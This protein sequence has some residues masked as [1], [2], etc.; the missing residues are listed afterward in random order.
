VSAATP[1]RALLACALAGGLLALA[2]AQQPAAKPAATKPAPAAAKPAPKPAAMPAKQPPA[3]PGPPPAD[4]E[5]LELAKQVLTGIIP[6]ELGASLV[7]EQHPKFAGYIE[8][9]FQ[10]QVVLAKPVASRTGA[11]RLEDV[12]GVY[13]MLQI[14]NKTML[15]NVKTGNRIADGCEHP[16]Q[17][18]LMERI[19]AERALTGASA[20]GLLDAPAAAA[21][22]A[23]APASVAGSAPPAAPAAPSAA[24]SAAAPPAPATSAASGPASAPPR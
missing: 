2:G 24:T 13:M 8:I 9:K 19:R 7:V 11:V 20:P 6:C 4:A 16:E 14:A 1:P 12:K 5:Q 3:P 21:S 15:M 18:A 23:A 10:K 17:K 22:A